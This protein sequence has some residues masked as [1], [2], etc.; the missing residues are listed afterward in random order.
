MRAAAAITLLLLLAPGTGW[1][2]PCGP[3]DYIPA[4]GEWYGADSTIGTAAMDIYP[5]YTR[6]DGLDEDGP[7]VV[8]EFDVPLATTSVDVFVTPDTAVDIDLFLLDPIC[9]SSAVTLGENSPSFSAEYTFGY[10]VTGGQTLYVIVDSPSSYGGLFDAIVVCDG[11]TYE[12]CDDLVDNDADGQIDCADADCTLHSACGATPELFCSDGA[13]NDGDG[14][15]DCDDPDCEDYYLCGETLC[16]DGIDNDSDGLVDCCDPNCESQTHCWESLNCADLTDN[17]CDSLVDCDDPDCNWD[18]GSPEVCDNGV[19]DDLDGQVDCSD[20]DDCGCDPACNAEIC[21][22]GVDD[23][24]DN[25]IDCNDCACWCD[26]ACPNECGNCFDG[27]DNDGDGYTDC[28]DLDC[29]ESED[30]CNE[31]PETCDDLIDNDG[32]GLVDCC[33][34]ECAGE[35]VCQAESSCVNG[36]D[37]DCDGLV[38]GDDPDCAG[39]DDD[40]ADDDSAADDDDDDTADDDSADDDDTDD[41]DDDGDDDNGGNYLDEDDGCACTAASRG[42]APS[43]A[44]IAGLLILGVAR[45][46]V[47]SARA[48]A[49]GRPR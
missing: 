38:D 40:T 48:N 29:L 16:Q 9:N 14:L 1:A 37:D 13:D 2:T 36:Y 44:L 35:S 8:L 47:H 49:D 39:D 3:T 28:E 12:E 32:D 21:D 45:R 7:E 23:D 33:D 22:N 5:G 27:V 4:C 17:D 34:D 6:L 19:D 41:D 30:A 46:R 20:L 26:P 31:I 10:A 11:G 25:L 24:G 15:I 42:T 18:C 43:L